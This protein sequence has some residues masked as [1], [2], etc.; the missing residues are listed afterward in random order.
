MRRQARRSEG[1]APRFAALPIFPNQSVLKE[2]EMISARQ[3]PAARGAETLEEVTAAAGLT[4]ED[5]VGLLMAGATVSDLLE[6]AH[7]VAS[8][9]LN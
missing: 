5:V 3:A 9:R 4:L 6:Y 1:N 8:D 2:I 7:A